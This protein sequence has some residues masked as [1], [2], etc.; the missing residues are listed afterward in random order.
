LSTTLTYGPA[1]VVVA[2]DP[3]GAQ[4]KNPDELVVCDPAPMTMSVKGIG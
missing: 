1:K 2:V 3:D 4:L